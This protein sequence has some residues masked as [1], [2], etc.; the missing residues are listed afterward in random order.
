[1]PRPG[2]HILK[3]EQC[4]AEK[5]VESGITTMYCCAQKMVIVEEGV[6]HQETTLRLQPDK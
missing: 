2:L 5:E 6:E 1:M 3:C 4:G